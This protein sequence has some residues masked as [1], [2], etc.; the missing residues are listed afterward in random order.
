[1]KKGDPSLGRE[2][3][4]VCCLARS[5]PSFLTTLRLTVMPS[6]NTCNPFPGGSLT[7]VHQD[8]V[9]PVTVVEMLAKTQEER[10]SLSPDY[11]AGRG[12]SSL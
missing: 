3:P 2:T 11:E 4:G 6:Q 10:W 12:Q 1:M 7:S 5:C 8:N 9:P